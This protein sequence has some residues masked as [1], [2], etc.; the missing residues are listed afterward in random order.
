META[1]DVAPAAQLSLEVGADRQMQRKQAR[2]RYAAGETQRSIAA[3]FGVTQVTIY[4]WCQGVVRQQ[5]RNPELSARQAATAAGVSKE[6]LLIWIRSGRLPAR[7]GTRTASFG[8]IGPKEHFIVLK[9]DLDAAVATLE[10]CRLEGCDRQ[11]ADVLEDPEYELMDVQIAGGY[12]TILGVPML[13]D[14]TAIGAIA[15][16]RNEVRPFSEPEVRLIET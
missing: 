13:R 14:N 3:D 16:G 12:R 6:T 15:M 10:S 4:R 5:P 2:A 8:R 7:W 11:I 9:S 1:D